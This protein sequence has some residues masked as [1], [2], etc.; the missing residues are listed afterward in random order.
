MMSILCLFD[1]KSDKLRFLAVPKA[2]VTS[3]PQDLQGDPP[4]LCIGRFVIQIDFL[5]IYEVMIFLNNI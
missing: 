2:Q 4:P 1:L 5:F 3:Y